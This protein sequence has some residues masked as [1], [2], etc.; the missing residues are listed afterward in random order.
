V[1][2]L[3]V[4]SEKSAGLRV[5][6][7]A[8]EL[9]AIAVNGL[10]WCENEYDKARYEA[11]LTLAARLLALSDTRTAGE[12]EQAYRGDMGIRSPLVG[13]D[14]AI[15]DEAGRLLLVQRADNERW[16]MPGGLADVGEPPSTVAERETWEEC[17]LEVRAV[18]LVG[19]FDSRVL[20]APYPNHLYQLTFM[21]EVLGGELTVTHETLDNG[22]Y[23]E[24][25]IAGLPIHGVAGYRIAEAFRV[26]RGEQAQPHFH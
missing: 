2:R 4:E 11:A 19:V 14:A 23:S 13:V 1:G 20:K 18:R 5:A 17:G 25:E 6:E 24:E 7:I 10:Q 3:C 26:Y 21:C 8:D 22:Y 12:I 16:C 15:F 9:R